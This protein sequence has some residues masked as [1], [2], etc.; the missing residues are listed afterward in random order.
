MARRE[1]R[2][3]QWH[4]I[5]DLLPGKKSDTGRTAADN[6]KFVDAVLWIARTGSHWRELPESF[7]KRKTCSKISTQTMFW[8][9]KDMTVMPSSKSS[10][11]TGQMPSFHPNQTGLYNDCV[12]LRFIASAISSNASSTR[13][14][15]IAPSQPDM[16]SAAEIIWRSSIWFASCYGLN[17]CQQNLALRVRHGF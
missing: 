17:D 7:G 1:L 8:L 13:S 12:I 9:T 16:P 14:S 3:D 11:R 15:T 6:H 10:Q 4:R 5:K 2:N